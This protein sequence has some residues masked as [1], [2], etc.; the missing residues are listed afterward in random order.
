M[1]GFYPR[2]DV[3]Y[4]ARFERFTGCLTR[5]EYADFERD[6]IRLRRD[7]AQVIAFLN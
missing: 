4:L 1:P 6:E 7:K 5:R 2:H 3:P